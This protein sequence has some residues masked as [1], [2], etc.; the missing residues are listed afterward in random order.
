MPLYQQSIAPR[1]TL[2]DPTNEKAKQV[3]LATRQKQLDYAKAEEP[4]LSQAFTDAVNRHRTRTAGEH[5]QDAASL[6]GRAAMQVAQV[7]YELADLSANLMTG[8]LVDIDEASEGIF[9]DS[10][11]QRFQQAREVLHDMESAPMQARRGEIQRRAGERE[12]ANQAFDATNPTMTENFMQGARNFASAVGDTLEHGTVAADMALESV[13]Q[14]FVPGAVVGKMT[15]TAAEAAGKKFAKEGREALISQLPKQGTFKVG[16]S[17]YVVDSGKITNV[18]GKAKELKRPSAVVKAEAAKATEEGG[19]KFLASKEGKEL[20]KKI[21]DNLTGIGKAEYLA[22]EAG[23]E[24]IEKLSG[25]VGLTYT[26]T[27][28]GMSNAGDVKATILS[29]S[30]AELKESSDEYNRLRNEGKTHKEAARILAN[31]ARDI[32]AAIAGLMGGIAGKLTGASKL[33][34]MGF[35]TGTKTGNSVLN[36]IKN[37]PT[38]EGALREGIEETM[39]GASGTFAGNVAEKFTSDDDKKL[40]EGVIEGAASGLVAGALSGGGITGLVNLPK[41]IVGAQETLKKGKEYV[42][43]Q[44]KTLGLSKNAKKAI[45]NKETNLSNLSDEDAVSVLL[46]TSR[47]PEDEKDMP[48]HIKEIETR[49]AP[50][51]EAYETHKAKIMELQADFLPK[52]EAYDKL[53]EPTE[54]QEEEFG[55]IKEQYMG[56]INDFN[57]LHQPYIQANQQLEVLQESDA[58]VEQ[59]EANKISE[60][61]DAS[62]NKTVSDADLAADETGTTEETLNEAITAEEA[63]HLLRGERKLKSEVREIPHAIN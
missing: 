6:A 50:L 58:V 44:T 63:E 51:K 21:D 30:E 12:L 34:G 33:E 42:Q 28:E 18:T 39:Q 57:E 8:G 40:S 5:L 24:A 45:K 9:G 36:K 56:E 2:Y 14:M 38:V 27:A 60:K 32:A 46:H 22:S 61:L 62:M 59:N 49:I 7:P 23:R 11:P 3:E 20:V 15:R 41:N 37:L 1:N 47:I 19:K 13:P 43:K 54:E 16:K 4:A 29:S 35:K 17:K 52:Q 26:A 48:S 55:L 10:V 31:D 53:E 25:K